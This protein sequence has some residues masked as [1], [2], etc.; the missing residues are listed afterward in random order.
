MNKKVRDFIIDN[1]QK[2]D[3]TDTKKEFIALVNILESADLTID[4]LHDVICNGY[5]EFFD[6]IDI[7][8]YWQTDRDVVESVM[9]CA[10]FFTLDEF[11]AFLTDELEFAKNYDNTHED[12]DEVE[13]FYKQYFTD[14]WC[15]CTITQTADGYVIRVY[16]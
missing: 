9:N 5:D 14:E 15:D 4:D 2:Y 7:G 1:W 16:C 6:I 10:S 3:L 8:D 11:S 13:Y 12:G